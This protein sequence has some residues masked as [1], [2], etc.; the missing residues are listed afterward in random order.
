MKYHRYLF[1]PARAGARQFSLCAASCYVFAHTFKD[2]LSLSDL[3]WRERRRST[4]TE[5]IPHKKP[6]LCYLRPAD[7]I[8]VAKLGLGPEPLGAHVLIVSN[9]FHQFQLPHRVFSRP[10]CRNFQEFS[11]P[12]HIYFRVDACTQR[13]PSS[14]HPERSVDFSAAGKDD[15]GRINPLRA[16]PDA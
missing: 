6:S 7:Q 2:R 4:R 15:D 11:H 3:Q 1:S 12:S 10:W 9:G 5:K 13:P 8:S 14:D 16:P